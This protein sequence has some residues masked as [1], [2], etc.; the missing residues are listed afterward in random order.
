MIAS[1]VFEE[2]E[3]A[4]G[5]AVASGMAVGWC[6]AIKRALLDRELVARADAVRRRRHYRG[7]AELGRTRPMGE[8]RDVELK[9]RSAGPRATA[10]RVDRLWERCSVQ[11]PC[12]FRFPAPSSR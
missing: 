6:G 5:C 1:E 7:G 4:V 11:S 9:E 12:A 8:I 3:Q 2:G 10:P